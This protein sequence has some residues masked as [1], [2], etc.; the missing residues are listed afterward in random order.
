MVSDANVMVVPLIVKS[1]ETPLDI[2]WPFINIITFE[3]A[4]GA[5]LSVKVSFTPFMVPEGVS[6]NWNVRFPPEAADEYVAISESVD[7]GILAS[8]KNVMVAVDSV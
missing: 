4:L 5:V 3:S 6:L 2:N 7:S 8:A 1:F